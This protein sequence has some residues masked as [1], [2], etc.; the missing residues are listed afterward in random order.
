M[1]SRL[2]YKEH[3]ET[4]K[5]KSK[6]IGLLRK[7]QNLLSQKSLIK[8]YKSFIRPHMDYRDIIYNQA[9]NASFHWKLE[10]IQ[11]NVALAIAGAILGTS[12]EKLYQEFNF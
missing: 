3:L 6:T 10:L 8:V 5:K 2:D 11:Y 9:Y 12:K 1:Y 4:I 7:L